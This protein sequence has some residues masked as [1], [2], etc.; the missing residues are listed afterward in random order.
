MVRTISQR[1]LRNDNAAVMR[2]V[3]AGEDFVVTRRGVPLARIVPVDRADDLECERPARN[4]PR[5][6]E[7]PRP[8][9]GGA[10][11]PTT[12]EVLDDLRGER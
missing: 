1:E 4:R 7:R 3:E 9:V 11:G 8:V 6:S 2:G 5:W 10:G 12:D